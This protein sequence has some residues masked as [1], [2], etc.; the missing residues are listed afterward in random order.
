MTLKDCTGNASKEIG[1]FSFIDL[2]GSERGSERGDSINQQV[3]LEGAE[4]NKSLLALKECIRKIDQD[5]GAHLPFRQSKLTQVLK[6]SFIST[7]L[8]C[9]TCMIACISPDQ[10][11]FEHSLNTLRYAD[12]VKELRGGSIDRL[13]SFAESNDN[14][15]SIKDEEDIMFDSESTDIVDKQME[16]MAVLHDL[17]ELVQS[18]PGESCKSVYDD[19]VRLKDKITAKYPR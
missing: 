12:R 4:I 16:C 18:I 5:S 9:R 17:A 7:T 10:A 13:S 2:A 11:S 14:N 8:K 19:L 6:D 15:D 3:R 1:R